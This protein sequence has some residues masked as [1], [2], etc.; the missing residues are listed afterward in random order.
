MSDGR[1]EDCFSEWGLLS[2]IGRRME[3]RTTVIAR[4]TL[5]V[6]VVLVAALTTASPAYAYLDPSTGS[7]LIS[8]VIGIVAALA[9]AVKMFWYRSLG[10][11]RH[12]ARQLRARHT[13]DRRP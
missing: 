10:L 2:E 4:Q 11:L 3:D 13:P 9:L 5:R 1:R 8:A 12:T 6:L 7:M